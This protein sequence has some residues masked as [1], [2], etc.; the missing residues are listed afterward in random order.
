MYWS[1]K[2]RYA[3]IIDVMSINRY[4]NLRQF[5]HAAD[6]LQKDNL[7]NKNNRLHKVAPVITHSRE[8]CINIE[9]ERDNSVDKQMIS[10]K[11][12]YSGTRQYNPQ[13]P[14]KWGF[15]N[16][17]R[18]ASS[19]MIY[20]FFLYAGSLNKTEKYTGTFV[21]KKLIETLPKQLNFRLYFDNSFCTI[22][23]CRELK[24]LGFPTVAT[25]CN[26]PTGC[27]CSRM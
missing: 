3:P 17:V 19:G 24:S 2:T 7:K 18:A 11:T 20:D 27:N 8:T 12:K 13:K 25:G 21:V 16:F 14:V 22:D 1:E 5:T 15:K 9:A 10:A 23:L 26:L 4:K 6:N